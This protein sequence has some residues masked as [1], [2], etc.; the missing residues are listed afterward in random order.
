MHYCPHYLVCNKLF[1]MLS[2]NP[3][4]ETRLVYVPGRGSFLVSQGDTVTNEPS[5]VEE[6]EATYNTEARKDYDGV[7]KVVIEEMFIHFLRFF[8]ERPEADIDIT[9][10][11]FLDADIGKIF[12]EKGSGASRALPDKIVKVYRKS[13]KRESFL[14]HIE[15]QQRAT[16]SFPRR[17]FRYYYLL[18]ERY[19]LPVTAMAIITGYRKAS[20]T[21]YVSRG[22]WGDL[23]YNYRTIQIKDQ[24]EEGL[25]KN[26][27]PFALVM[28]A[29]KRSIQARKRTDRQQ[30]E[31][32]EKIIR[33]I[34]SRKLSAR[35]RGS[36][37]SFVRECLR[38]KDPESYAAFD[39]IVAKI[40]KQ[41]NAMGLKEYFSERGH[42]EGLKEGRKEGL[43]EG[44]KE[45]RKEGKKE[46]LEAGREER[47]K[48][49]IL[50]M[51]KKLNFKDAK[52]ANFLEI[53]LASVEETLK[54]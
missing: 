18:E 3:L 36:L 16:R 21:R 7:W 45:G 29:A 13:G 6:K 32:F 52:I 34:K 27:N 49:V 42:K 12:R 41:K 37:Y 22:R 33:E 25:L 20:A 54:R 4:S 5:T 47:E 9:R 28:L 30:I 35:E 38:F 46:G 23:Q 1:V 11:D 26:E 50:L 2:G 51:R 15:V 8:D 10:F 48:E 14:F 39:K 44:R 53:P 31:D 40:T 24:P 19:G 43:Q 17:M